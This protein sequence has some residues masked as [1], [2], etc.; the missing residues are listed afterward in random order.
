MYIEQVL[1]IIQSNIFLELPEFLHKENPS[2]IR[3]L[4][5]DINAVFDKGKNKT[6]RHGEA[7]RWIMFNKD[8]EPIG[9]IA[10]FINKKYRNKGDDIPVGGIGFFECINQQDAANLLFETARHWLGQHGMQAMD[11]PINFGERDKWWGL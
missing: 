2:F 9:R 11:G 4:D 6:F 5:K 8:R 10:A 7:S 3:P 1:S